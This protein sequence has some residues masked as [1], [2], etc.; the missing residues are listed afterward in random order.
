MEKASRLEAEIYVKALETPIQAQFCFSFTAP[1]NVP[2]LFLPYFEHMT[3][4]FCGRNLL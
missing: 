3:H 4:L 2:P 1:V